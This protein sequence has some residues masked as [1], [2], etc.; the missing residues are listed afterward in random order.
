[1]SVAQEGATILSFWKSQNWDKD[2]ISSVS[3]ILKNC[4]VEDIQIKSYLDECFSN[5]KLWPMLLE[6]HRVSVMAIQ[7]PMKTRMGVSHDDAEAFVRKYGAK[8][9]EMGKR[10]T[11]FPIPITTLTARKI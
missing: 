2:V 10:G 4:A 11:V 8:V 1:L 9:D 5:S 7:K 6:W 3:A